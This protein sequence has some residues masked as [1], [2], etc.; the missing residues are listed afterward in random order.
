MGIMDIGVLMGLM[1][2]IGFM[3]LIWYQETDGLIG[4]MG[5]M[6]LLILILILIIMA[7]LGLMGLK[8]IGVLMGLMYVIGRL[9]GPHWYQKTHGLTDFVSLRSL[10]LLMWSCGFQGSLW[11][12]ESQCNRALMA[13]HGFSRSSF[14]VTHARSNKW[15]KFITKLMCAHL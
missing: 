14:C 3:G 12:H 13:A 9:H 2:V 8:D 10:T 11:S 1:Y 5:L 4:F 7:L 6:S 15:G